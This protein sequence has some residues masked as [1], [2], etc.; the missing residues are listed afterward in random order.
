MNVTRVRILSARDVARA[1]PMKEAIRSAKEAFVALSGGRAVQPPRAVI[2]RPDGRGEALFM[3]AWIEGGAFMGVK[4]VTLF[5]DNPGRG[6]PRLQALLCLFDG[7]TGTPRAVMDAAALTAIRTGAASGAATELLAREDADTAA[8]FGAGVQGRTQ[9]EA[10][11]AVRPVREVRVFDP[12]RARAEAFARAASER[13]G[14][15]VRAAASPAEALEGADVVCTATTA[16]APVFR[17]GELAP[18]AHVNAVG[19]YKPEAREIPGDTVRRALV[20]VDHRPAA[21]A[22]AGD[23]LVPMK[24]GL[25]GPE[26]IHAE[27]GEVAAGRRPGRTAPEQVTLFKSVGT[28]AQD[29]SAAAHVLAAAERLG[30]GTEAVL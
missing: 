24:E 16:T 19:A 9:L 15:P 28:A 30:L 7:E 18:G 17:D 23:L 12:D 13:L 26:H 20:V 22:E 3:P 1:L 14:L 6:L 4:T 8:L 27:L 21:L 25:I 11:C 2:S 29:L 10:L 5:G